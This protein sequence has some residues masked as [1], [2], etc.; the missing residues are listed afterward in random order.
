M[1]KKLPQVSVGQ[2]YKKQIMKNYALILI[3]ATLVGCATSPISLNEATSVPPNRI[4][5][6][7][8]KTGSSAK[9]IVVRDTGFQAGGVYAHFFINETRAA[10]LDTGEAL[11]LS[12]PPG[13]YSFG[14]HLTDPLHAENMFSI[15][16][17]IKDGKIYRYRI[18]I[19]HNGARIVH[20]FKE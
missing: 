20:I 10:S 5:Y 18:L 2:L 7:P 17:S 9:I 16:Q 13:D 4:Y 1:G 6:N 15:D 12:I 19:D 8:A 11:Y 3:V 14:V